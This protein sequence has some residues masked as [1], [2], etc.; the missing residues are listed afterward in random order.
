MLKIKIIKNSL[1]TRA[2]FGKLGWEVIKMA[3][4]KSKADPSTIG[5]NS[6]QVEGQGTTTRETGS[7][8]ADS[9]RNKQKRS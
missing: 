9:S 8:R 6:S 4:T 1:I 5:L 2:F 7:K 3:K